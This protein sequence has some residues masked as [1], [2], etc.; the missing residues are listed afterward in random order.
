MAKH[1]FHY[2]NN[3]GDSMKTGVYEKRKSS[4]VENF[5]F[6]WRVGLEPT[7]FRTTI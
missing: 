3:V 7:T 5:R 1:H 2:N 6:G 4:T